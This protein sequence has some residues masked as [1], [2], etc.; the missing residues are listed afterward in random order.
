MSAA[1]VATL[2][3]ANSFV[4]CDDAGA[5]HQLALRRGQQDTAVDYPVGRGDVLTVSVADLPEIEKLEVRVGGDGAI[6]LAMIGSVQ[7][8]GLGE[9]A[10]GQAI[11]ARASDYVKHP[12]VHAFVEHYRSRIVELMGMVAR[13]GARAPRCHEMFNADNV[14]GLSDVLVGRGA[15]ACRW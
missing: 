4:R 9:N 2:A 10:V 7:L 3:D 11:A 5:L 14:T 12:R 6:S 8:G 1:S 15:P 13:P